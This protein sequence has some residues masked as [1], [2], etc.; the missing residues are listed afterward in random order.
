MTQRTKKAAIVYKLRRMVL[1]HGGVLCM[2]VFAPRVIFCVRMCDSPKRD[3]V[4]CVEDLGTPHEYT[5]E[6]MRD[7]L[8]GIFLRPF[9]TTCHHHKFR[10]MP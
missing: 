7:F 2:G 4:K 10:T 1:V 5:M 6:E 8:V 3:C 9:F